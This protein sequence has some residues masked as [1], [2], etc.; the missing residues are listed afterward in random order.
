MECAHDIPK[1]TFISI[2]AGLLYKEEDSN[3]L[4]VG[5][6]HGDEYF[7]E[8][9]LIETA[10]PLKEGYEQGV[11]YESDSEEEKASDSDSDYDTKAEGDDDFTAKPRNIGS[12]EILTRSSR[13]EKIKTGG[14]TRQYSTDSE[15]DIVTMEPK[16]GNDTAAGPKNVSLRRLFGKNEK[17]YVMDAK[18]CGNVGRYFNVRIRATIL[19]PSLTN[20][21]YFPAF[22]RSQLVRAKRLR[23]HSRP[24][25][26]LDRLLRK[27]C[28]Q[29]RLGAD[30]ELQLRARQ[31]RRQGFKL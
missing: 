9:D 21:F 17:P 22:V 31:R 16:A 7:A 23:R 12:R 8:L 24:A 27:P 15:G 19:S 28:D 26:S 11:I 29:S 5:Q 2:Y 20:S 14:P 4:C 18:T 6:D 1:G 13:S 30:M 25:L 3:A 10:Q